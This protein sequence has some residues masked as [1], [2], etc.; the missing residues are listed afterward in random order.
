MLTIRLGGKAD[1]VWAQETVSKHHYL[2]CPVHPQARPMVYVVE[3]NGERVG[4]C[5]AGLPHATQNRKW[6]GYAHQPTQ[7]QVV[8]LSR[9]WLSPKLQY[10]GEW[11][12][13]EIVPGYTD[14]RGSFR[15]TTM[16]WLIKEVLCRIQKDRLAL[17]P[18]VYPHQPYHILLVIS[19]HDPSLHKGTIYK[20][21]G[22][23]PMYTNND[24]LPLPGPSGK[25]GWVWKLPTPNWSWQDI[26]IIRP[27]T[28][29]LNLVW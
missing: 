17:W 1:L 2:Q 20:L 4:L 22:A 28:M 26:Q 10:R 7:W 5:M 8:D 14:R 13:P 21:S 27:R 6:W 18:P 15:P 29:R 11:C 24:G 9:L 19:Y 3:L 12:Q 25:C 23:E 16:T